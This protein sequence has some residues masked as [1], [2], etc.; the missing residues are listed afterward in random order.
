MRSWHAVGLFCDDIRMEAERRSS[1]MGIFPD[2]LNMPAIP[3]VIPRV[4]LYVRI[5]MNVDADAVPLSALLR[6]PHGED[7]TLGGFDTARVRQ[8]QNESKERQASHAGFVIQAVG[9]MVQVKQPGRILLIASVGDEE[10][11]CGGLNVQL[12]PSTSPSASP[13]AP[14]SSQSRHA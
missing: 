11:V 3:G 5:H 8:A 10:S 1:L 6:F 12:Q 2:N 13:T 14:P 4:G 9:L 7:K